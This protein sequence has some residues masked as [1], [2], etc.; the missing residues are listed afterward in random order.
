MLAGD[1][2]QVQLARTLVLE[3]RLVGVT[4]GGGLK[5]IHTILFDVEI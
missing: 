4:K 1:S 2:G 3:E 5:V